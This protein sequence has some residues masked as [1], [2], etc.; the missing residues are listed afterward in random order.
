MHR[1]TFNIQE[2]RIAKKVKVIGLRV[3]DSGFR[4]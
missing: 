2:S 1:D 4:V 3:L